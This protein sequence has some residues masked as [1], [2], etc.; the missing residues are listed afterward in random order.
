MVKRAE[1]QR[2]EEAHLLE[3]QRMQKAE[4]LLEQDQLLFEKFLKENNQNL[5][6]AI[7]M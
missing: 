3:E 1:I 6:E 5:V 4:Q 2:L 7:Q